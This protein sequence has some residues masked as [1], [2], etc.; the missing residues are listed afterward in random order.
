MN[1]IEMAALERVKKGD[2]SVFEIIV[3]LYE[4][5][6]YNTA[7]RMCKNSEDAFDISQEVFLKVYKS[8]YSF[9]GESSLSTYIYRI[10]YNMCIDFLRKQKKQNSVSLTNED[11]E[12]NII[13]LDI[14]DNKA[15]PVEA[16]EAK[17]RG[18]VLK[19]C[20][21][22]LSDI[23]RE[24]IVLRDIE[25]LSYKEIAEIIGIEEGTVKSRIVRA[26]NNLKNLLLNK[27]NFFD[28]YKSKKVDIKKGGKS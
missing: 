13:E 6:V 14:K 16:F 23:H 15:G 20:I 10:T 27:G 17:E 19:N 25:G 22:E 3:N 21:N 9:K 11:D 1:D 8:I 5:K 2:V 24:M 12:G 4:K 18:E 7:L 28:N 26:R